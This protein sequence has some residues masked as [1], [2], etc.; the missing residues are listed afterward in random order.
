M[1]II[2]L[3]YTNTNDVIPLTDIDANSFYVNYS[4]FGLIDIQFDMSPN[5]N[6]YKHIKVETIL[7]YENRFFSINSINQRQNIVTIT[8]ML[9]LSA[10]KS[11][12]IKRVNAPLMLN[13]IFDT[14]FLNTG[15]TYSFT[16]LDPFVSQLYVDINY[17]TPLD[18][19]L[20]IVKTDVF[21]LVYKFDTKNKNVT[22]TNINA[23]NEPSGVYFT[24][25]LNLQNT[26]YKATSTEL[27][28]R[29]YAYGANGIS[30]AD[31]N[32]GK[33]YIDNNTYSNKTISTVFVDERYTNATSL[34]N[35]ATKKL[36]ELSTLKEYYQSTVLDIASV[37]DTYKSLLN[38]KLHDVITLIDRY[39]NSCILQRI[40]NIKKYP[41]KQYL[42][43]TT[44][45]NINYIP[46]YY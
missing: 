38:F 27:Y 5:S 19:L 35:A 45:N 34:L 46:N 40:T 42:N 1:S 43:E 44:L 33:E 21:S 10:L 39:N 3:L 28:T 37:N 8:A 13:V 12:I 6:L 2:L 30:I 15:W 18:A 9:D 31:V 25:E 7:E 36:K 24:D 29:L 23:V 32:G 26:V 22:V 41:L 17:S 20:N 16:N 14:I 4:Y 11:K